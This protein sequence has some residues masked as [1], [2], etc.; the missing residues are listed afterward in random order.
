MKKLIFILMVGSLFPQSDDLST[1][2]NLY[3]LSGE[4]YTGQ[5]ISSDD[6]FIIFKPLGYLTGQSI[7]KIKINKVVLADGTIIFKSTNKRNTQGIGIKIAENPILTIPIKWR[8]LL[9]EP[10][11]GFDWDSASDTLSNNQI[12]FGLSVY[13]NFPSNNKFNILTGIR[14]GLLNNNIYFKYDDRNQDFKVN[15][16]QLLY[17]I[18]LGFQYK[19]FEDFLLCYET[20]YQIKKNNGGYIETSIGEKQVIEPNDDTFKKLISSFIIRYYIN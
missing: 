14:M 15:S 4:S 1:N 6:K 20:T 5:F 16:Q 8:S 9:I 19:I 12:D 18:N 2:D 7:E 10:K 3:L 13:Y 11:L 17:S